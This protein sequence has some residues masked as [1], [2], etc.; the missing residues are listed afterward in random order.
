MYLIKGAMYTC[1]FGCVS[2]KVATTV[3][4]KQIFHILS[5]GS[6][7][8][9]LPKNSNNV[10]IHGFQHDKNKNTHAKTRDFCNK[11]CKDHIDIIKIRKLG[12]SKENIKPYINSKHFTDKINILY[13]S[14]YNDGNIL[15]LDQSY[16]ID[17]LPF[18]KFHSMSCKNI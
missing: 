3:F 9:S 11:I 6:I 4:D 18:E 14:D 7:S 17:K 15:I 1:T 13:Q 12:N 8:W 2:I 5:Y 10:I 16:D